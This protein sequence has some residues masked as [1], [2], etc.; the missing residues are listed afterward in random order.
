MISANE[1]DLIAQ[2]FHAL[3]RLTFHIFNLTNSLLYKCNIFCELCTS[4]CIK[5]KMYNVT[6]NKR[7]TSHCVYCS[8]HTVHSVH[9]RDCGR[10]S[11]EHFLGDRCLYIVR[12][13][14]NI[15]CSNSLYQIY[16]VQCTVHTVY[17][18]HMIHT[19]HNAE[20][21]LGDICLY[22]YNILYNVYN[23]Y[24]QI[25]QGTT[26]SASSGTDVWGGIRPMNE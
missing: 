6:N 8:L 15:H 26:Q 13:V 21:L 20:S 11:V 7:H 19:V 12:R 23:I 16:I 3:R 24:V 25:V 9:H 2:L 17:I 1:L 4:M 5:C 22:I 10:Y 18:V 14:L